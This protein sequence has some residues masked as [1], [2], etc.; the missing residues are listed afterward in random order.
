MAFSSIEQD[1]IYKCRFFGMKEEILIAYLLKII[2]NKIM[3]NVK[4]TNL[5]VI[6]NSKYNIFS[7]KNQNYG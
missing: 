2:R 3:D 6:N 7:I 1:N 4:K 5:S